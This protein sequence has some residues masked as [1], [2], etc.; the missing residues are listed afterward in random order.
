MLLAEKQNYYISVTGIK[1]IRIIYTLESNLSLVPSFSMLYA[2]KSGRAC[3]VS[4]RR[5][6]ALAVLTTAT[7]SIIDSKGA[8][9]VACLADPRLVTLAN[10][11]AC[12]CEAFGRYRSRS[13]R[14]VD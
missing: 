7:E 6:W 12:H 13:R 2:E 5:A 1:F 11:I 10:S 9:I 4:D 3:D 8:L 14:T